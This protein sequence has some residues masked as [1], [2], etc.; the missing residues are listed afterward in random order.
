MKKFLQMLKVL[1]CDSGTNYKCKS[2]GY[3]ERNQNS[4]MYSLCTVRI[5][6]R[7]MSN[8]FKKIYFCNDLTAANQL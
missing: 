5:K 4:L 2:S 8:F 7:N 3:V 6:N 1:I